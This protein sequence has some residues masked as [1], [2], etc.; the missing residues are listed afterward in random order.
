MNEKVNILDIPWV[1]R[2][3]LGTPVV[4]ILIGF[5]FKFIPSSLNSLPFGSWLGGVIIGALVWKKM[6]PGPL[7]NFMRPL[8][9]FFGTIITLLLVIDRFGDIS[10]PD[11]VPARVVSFSAAVRLSTSHILVEATYPNG[12]TIRFPVRATQFHPVPVPG[13][14]G[15]AVIGRG[16]FR[17]RYRKDLSF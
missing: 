16:L 4:G 3:F 8:T 1:M 14:V 5:D 6:K 17:I 12:S 9:L 13:D 7:F 10:I 2:V 11:A 15:K